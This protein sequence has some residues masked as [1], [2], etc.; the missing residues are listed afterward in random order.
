MESLGQIYRTAIDSS[1]PIL[2]KNSVIHRR[3]PIDKSFLI[4]DQSLFSRLGREFCHRSVDF[5][6]FRV[7]QVHL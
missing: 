3:L 4:S 1:R 5:T 6:A 2:L 7:T